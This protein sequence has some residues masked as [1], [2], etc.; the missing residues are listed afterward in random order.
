M[1]KSILTTPSKLQ[2]GEDAYLYVAFDKDVELRIMPLS[3]NWLFLPCKIT[4][5]K[6][7]PSKVYYDLALSVE[8]PDEESR[9]IRLHSVDSALLFTIDEYVKRTK[10]DFN[11]VGLLVNLLHE[12]WNQSSDS[13]PLEAHEQEEQEKKWKVFIE[14]K[15]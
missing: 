13:C 2:V 5:V 14:S 8:L 11:Q 7:T 1:E 12:F 3:V 4:A 15:F 10:E 6:F 9:N